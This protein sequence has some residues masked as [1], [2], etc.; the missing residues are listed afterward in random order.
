MVALSWMPKTIG[1]FF[2]GSVQAVSEGAKVLQ[3]VLQTPP[4]KPPHYAGEKSLQTVF[5]NGTHPQR[6]APLGIPLVL[7]R[8]QVET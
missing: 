8:I 6:G 4:D 3:Q 5:R 2:G 1:A 7:P